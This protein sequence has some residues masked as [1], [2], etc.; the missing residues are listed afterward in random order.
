[1]IEAIEFTY[2]IGPNDFSIVEGYLKEVAKRSIGAYRNQ[3]SRILRTLNHLNKPLQEITMIDIKEYFDRVID[4]DDIKLSSKETHRSYLKSFFYYVQAYFLDQNITFQN[5]VPI[6]KVYKFTKKNKDFKKVSEQDGEI[7]TETE[8]QEILNQAK[9]QGFRDFIL[10]GI[11]TAT[12]MRI[13]EAL[14]IR[15]ENIN[16][17]ERYIETGFEMDARKSDKG[18]L[19]FFPKGFKPYLEKY[20]LYLNKEQGWLFKGTKTHLTTPGWRNR[21]K[22]YYEEKYSLFHTFRRTMIT[23]RIKDMNCDLL[24]SE[25][26]MN[27]APSSVEGKHYLKLSIQEKREYYDKYFPYKNIT[28]F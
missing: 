22:K 3:K 1:M 9:L 24:I 20:L 18:L 13:S 8:L 5:P 11:I 6:T 2:T 21:C 19:F 27:H 15:I 16:L 17:E 12:G 10:Y 25:M 28:Y 26:L 23:R 14:T 7:Y 4:I